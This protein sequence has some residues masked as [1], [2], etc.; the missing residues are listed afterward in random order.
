MK[1]DQLR[2]VSSSQGEGVSNTMLGIYREICRTENPLNHFKNLLQEFRVFKSILPYD[3]TAACNFSLSCWI[4][5]ADFVVDRRGH[6]AFGR[7]SDEV[8]ANSASGGEFVK[9]RGSN[10]VSTIGIRCGV[11]E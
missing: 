9:T 2:A 10:G 8:S 4:T 7:K 5:L 11:D 1:N 3:A 6:V